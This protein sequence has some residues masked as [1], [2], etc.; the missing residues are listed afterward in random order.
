MLFSKIG[1]ESYKELRIIVL[2]TRAFHEQ[3]YLVFRDTLY[4]GNFFATL[5]TAKN[6]MCIA[7]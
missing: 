6:K 1:L 3:I 7:F 5:A 2:R 4:R